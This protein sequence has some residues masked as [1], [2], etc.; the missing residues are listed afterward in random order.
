M[1][2]AVCLLAY[3]MVLL[4]IAP[5]VLSKASASGAAPRLGITV[6]V[7]AMASVPAAWLGAVTLFGVDLTLAWGHIDR[8]LSDCFAALRTL[9]MGGYG[10]FL[11]AGLAILTALTAVALATVAVR[12]GAALRRGRIHTRRHA[13]AAQLAARG[14]PRGPG[15]ALIVDAPHRIVYCLA[16]RPSTIVITRPAL[17]ALDDPQLAAVL[18]HEQAH[19]SGRHHQLLAFTAALAKVLPGMALFTQGS[20]EIARLAEMCAD[21]VAAR[22]HSGDTVVGALLALALPSP[23]TPALALGAAGLGVAERVERLLVPPNP[24][25]AWLYQG[26]ALGALLIGPLTIGAL[27]VTRSPLCITAALG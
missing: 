6:W 19:L 23:P 8:L 15:G 17:S 3:S 22:R 20:A 18:A 27:V 26:A 5:P 9:A 12:I 24:T 11:Q 14:G 10:G 4:V 7:V 13:E 21:D 1:S 2:T 16:G 25:R